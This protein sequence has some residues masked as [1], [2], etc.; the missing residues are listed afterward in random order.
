MKNIHSERSDCNIDIT[1][2][3]E[4]IKYLNEEITGTTSRL[5]ELRSE[6]ASIRATQYTGDNICP[7][8]GQ[9]LP[10]NMIQDALQKFEEYKQN[11]IKENQSRG[12]SLSA[13]VESYREELNRH[14]EELVEHSKRL[15]PLT[16]VLQGCMIV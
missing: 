13:Q 4:R 8:C 10:D 5:E 15:L 11:R 3:K 9:P 12:K 16:N 2:A 1:R 14:N 6:W 7:H